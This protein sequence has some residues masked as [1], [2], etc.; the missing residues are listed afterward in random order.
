[1]CFWLGEGE[2]KPSASCPDH[3]LGSVDMIAEKGLEFEDKLGP[4]GLWLVGVD[5]GR[6]GSGCCIMHC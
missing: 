5:A 2:C 6:V 3:L 4:S 1:M